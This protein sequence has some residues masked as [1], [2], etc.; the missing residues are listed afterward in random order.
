MRNA[1]NRL[2]RNMKSAGCG[3]EVRTLRGQTMTTAIVGATVI[4]ATGNQPV[5]N[6]TVLIDDTGSIVSIT[7]SEQSE[8]PSGVSIVDAVGKFVIPGLID[9]NVHL[10]LHC[11]P[12]VLLRF[13]HGVYDDLILE[14]AQITLRAGFTT[15]FDTWGPLESL[16]RTRD[17]ISNGTEVGSRIYFAGHM[18][19][20]GGPWSP[21]FYPQ[22]DINSAVMDEVNSH[23]THGVG[24]E[25]PWRSSEDVGIAVREY[26]ERT[27]VDFIKFGGSV[28]QHLLYQ[29]FSPYAQQAIVEEAHAAGLVAQACTTTAEAVKTVMASGVDLL[30]HGDFTGRYPMPDSLVE[31]IASEQMPCVALLTTDRF[32]DAIGGDPSKMGD[33]KMGDLYTVKDQN[34]R[35][36]IAAG[37][38]LLLGTDGGVYD[39]NWAT[40]PVW[41]PVLAVPDWYGLLGTSHLYWLQAAQERSMKPM[42]IL[43]SA[44]RNVAEA[45]GKLDEIGT[46]EP[47][48]RADLLVLEGNPL[49]DASNYGRIAQIFQDGQLIDRDE[50]P[51]NPVLTK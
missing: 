31:Q 42:D 45:Y 15:V 35:A 48:K 16:R 32:L 9:A 33:S 12:D 39:S 26:I 50:L 8:L 46:L 51:R 4:D 27:G 34:D 43:M 38:R 11:D 13:E 47:G 19:G 22:S 25:L 20:N 37:A 2:Y 1:P 6:A 41:G 23:W 44:T 17:K 36:L 5:E 30:Q 3:Q 28:H 7:P 49:E 18:I 40:S 29:V 14:A 21:D 10:L 24:D